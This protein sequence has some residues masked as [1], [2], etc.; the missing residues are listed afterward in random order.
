[1]FFGDFYVYMSFFFDVVVNSIGGMFVDVYCFVKGELIL[2]FFI[3]ED[4]ML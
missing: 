4:G 1:M 3:S 2:F